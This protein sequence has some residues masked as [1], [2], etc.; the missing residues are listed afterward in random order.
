MIGAESENPNPIPIPSLWFPGKTV[1]YPV[2][3]SARAQ[4]MAK[5]RE[6]LIGLLRN[7]PE[8]D[9]ELSLTDLVEKQSAVD[10]SVVESSFSEQSRNRPGGLTWKGKHKKSKSVSGSGRGV[11]LN[12]FVP[13]SMTRSLTRSGSSVSTRAPLDCNG[14][15]DASPGCLSVIWDRSKSRSRRQKGEN[16]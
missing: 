6:E 15:V 7:V 16:Q 11:L 1:V 10:D 4:E 13:V 12:L 14:R 5:Y 2:T 9:Y 3:A 8:S